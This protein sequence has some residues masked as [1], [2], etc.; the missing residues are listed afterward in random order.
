MAL[1]TYANLQ[2]AVLTWLA[3]PGDTLISGSVP[4]MITLFE[5]EARR[6][7]YT[8]LGETTTNLTTVAGTATLALP[9]LFA[10]ARTVRIDSS[11]VDRL[12][13]A[14]PEEIDA[15]WVGSTQ[16]QPIVYT[17]EGANIRFAP[18]P[19]SAYTVVFNYVAGVPALATT[20]PNWLLTNHPD[21][22]LFGTLVEAEAF[23]GNDERVGEWLQRRNASL[24]SIMAADRKQRWSGSALQMR[25]DT[26]NP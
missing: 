19:D 5:A 18:T 1:D 21:S 11:P 17:I 16:A 24:V 9:A 3:R 14:T 12:T 26:G 8:R 2:T 15:V 13:Y 20:N 6:Q 10:E 25:G 23:I 7:L 4:D 22:Y